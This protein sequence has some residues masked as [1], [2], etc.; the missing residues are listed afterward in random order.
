M[1]LLRLSSPRILSRIYRPTFHL[2]KNL[3]QSTPSE[4]SSTVDL[5]DAIDNFT[6]ELLQKKKYA[7]DMRN[8]KMKAIKL[9]PKNNNFNSSLDVGKMSKEQLDEIFNSAL[10]EC[11]DTAIVELLRECSRTK[12]CPSQD[13]IL[14]LLSV[15]AQNGEVDLINDLEKLCKYGDVRLPSNF[16][17]DVYIAQAI[18]EKGLVIKGLDMFQE[19]YM[20]NPFLRRYIRITLRRLISKEVKN[21]SEAV[22]LYM[23]KVAKNIINRH[24]DYFFLACI[25]ESCYM[26]ELYSDQ[27]LALNLLY[28]DRRLI[29]VI[30]NRLPFLLITTLRSHRTEPVY[31]LLECFHVMNM[32][33]Q[34]SIVAMAFLD[35][36]FLQV[37]IGNYSEI[38]RWCKES[39]VPLPSIYTKKF[40]KLL[41]KSDSYG[42][43]TESKPKSIVKSKNTDLSF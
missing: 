5:E 42:I 10:V 15:C 43:V 39:N 37:S 32:K 17:F 22:L 7:W 30:T 21:N 40:L 8:E 18:W 2:Q 23:L 33:E 16:N 35:Y 41:L 27:K 29:E 4:S 24:K 20:I 3:K 1:A 9:P 34:C 12:T 28:E 13:L 14:Q 31:K 36:H 25:W 19:L 11:N 6:T 26:S 38:I